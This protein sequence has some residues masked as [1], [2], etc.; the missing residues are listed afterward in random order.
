MK[1]PRPESPDDYAA[2]SSAQGG[3]RL[4][5]SSPEAESALVSSALIAP[6]ILDDAAEIITPAHFHVQAHA[7]IWEQTVALHEAKQKIDTVV[8]VNRMRDVGL[9]E[10]IGG[11]GALVNLFGYPTAANW[12]HYADIVR[13]KATLREVITQCHALTQRCYEEQDQWRD[14]TED[15]ATAFSEI[16]AGGIQENTVK[17]AKDFAFQAL[18]EIEYAYNNRGRT[19]GIPTGFVDLD[20]MIGGWQKGY[21]Y[22]IGARPAMGKTSLGMEFA[23]ETSCAAM[24][25]ATATPTLIFSIEMTGVQL[26]KRA[27]LRL[28]Q[29]NLQRARDGFFS[30]GDINHLTAAMTRIAKSKLFIDETAALT[31]AHLRARIRRFVKQQRR[32]NGGER[33]D[34]KPDVI[35][36]IDYLQRIKGSSKRSEDARY[37]ELQEIA[38][39]ISIIAKE[40]QI[41]IIIL[42]Q[43]KR[44]KDRRPDAEPDMSDFRECGDIEQEAHVVGLLHRPHYYVKHNVDK[45]QALAEE[46]RE[47]FVR[48]AMWRGMPKEKAEEI[49]FGTEDLE[50]Y[51]KLIIDKQRE[52]PVGP[53]DLRFVADYTQFST[54][55]PE[56]TRYS[57]NAQ[58]RQAPEE[59]EENAEEQ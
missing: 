43:L 23:L 14:I 17:P 51:A 18:Q 33:K 53:I 11:A 58:H 9:L 21:T 31:I 42:A 22:Y 57:N 32:I 24:S 26:I 2:A 25:G 59:I 56:R 15:A 34:G 38:Q 45:Q 29:I 4:L 48:E 49:R 8:M 10:K 27:I 20:R 50:R 13:Q 39:G 7:L 47:R 54:W 19:I 28:A 16:A 41:P 12:R 30:Q 37:L 52:G 6:D 5:P 46:L 36:V 1:S 3:H 40:L 44:P 35:I 55:D